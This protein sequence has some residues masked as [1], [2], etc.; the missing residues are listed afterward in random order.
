MLGLLQGS[1]LEKRQ[2]CTMPRSQHGPLPEI[3][4]LQSCAPFNGRQLR[5]TPNL[6]GDAIRNFDPLLYN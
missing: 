5:P 2:P 4:D 1:I 6:G 3:T